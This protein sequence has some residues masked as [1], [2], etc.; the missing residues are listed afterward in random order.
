[1]IEGNFGKAAV[2]CAVS[3]LS[4]YVSSTMTIS[5]LWTVATS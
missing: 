5:A 3:A 1:M 2:S 4:I